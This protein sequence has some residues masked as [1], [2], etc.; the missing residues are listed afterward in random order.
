MLLLWF[1]FA[2]PWWLVMLSTFFY[3]WW[4]FEYLL[5]ENVY[6]GLL[7]IY[8]IVFVLFCFATELDEYLYIVI[9]TLIR[10]VACRYF[11]PFHRLPFHF[12]NGF[13]C[14]A[15]AFQFD[16]VPFNYFCI[17][18]CGL[19]V[20]AIKS[21]TK[22]NFKKFP[23]CFLLVV[24]WFQE[25]RFKSSIHFEL[26]FRRSGV[27]DLWLRGAFSKIRASLVAV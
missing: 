24:L 14:E 18:V 15:E 1:W 9:L 2:F 21:I 6:S 27:F 10:L 4:A 12:V 26:T 5:W 11:L 8:W 17:A 19:G 22:T 23:L 13:F 16:V 25:F 3:T 20:I 7:L